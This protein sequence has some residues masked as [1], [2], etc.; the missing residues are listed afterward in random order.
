[1]KIKNLESVLEIG[2]EEIIVKKDLIKKINANKPLRIK[3]G[4]DPTRPDIHL[5]HAVTLWNLKKLQEMGHKIIFLIGDYTTKIGDPSGKNKTRPIL[6]DATIKKNA[7]TYLKQVGKILDIKKTEI[8]FNSEWYKKFTF[9]QLLELAANFTVAR[10]IERDDFAKRLKSG[11]DIGLHEL[12]Y[13]LMQAY[14]SIVLKS[15]VE[16]GGSDQKF[17]MLAA[18][19]LQ[20]KMGFVP[21]DIIHMKLLIGSDGVN[22]M[23]KSLDNYIG[24]DEAAGQ[25]YGK[26]MSIPDTLIEDYAIL[27][28]RL[29]DNDL[30]KVKTMIKTNPRDAKAF[31]AKAI[32]ELYHPGEGGNAE[33]DFNRQF[34]DKEIPFDIPEFKIKKQKIQ[35]IDLLVETKMVTSKSEARRLIEQRG[36]KIDKTII[37]DVNEEIEIYNNL[38]LQVGKRKFVKLIEK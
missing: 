26:V 24:V 12:L 20:K 18:R 4:V 6:D 29:V 15:D 7:E 31:V 35:L 1:M 17:N 13:P 2:V 23:S 8:R 36:V 27:A 21:Q 9:A 25:Q 3:H 19:E 38:I 28:A 10:I 22:K 37:G 11:S 32:V 34:K 14:D 33:A 30:K 5:G 16:I